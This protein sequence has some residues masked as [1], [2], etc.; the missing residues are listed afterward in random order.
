[1]FFRKKPSKDSRDP[2]P[3]RSKPSRHLGK[4]KRGKKPAEDLRQRE[5]DEDDEEEEQGGELGAVT[6]QEVQ[7]PP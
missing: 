5:E 4:P 2:D 6:E 1:M 7:T 3:S